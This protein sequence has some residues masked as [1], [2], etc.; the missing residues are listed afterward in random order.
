MYGDGDFAPKVS[1]GRCYR[2][3][4]LGCKCM[5]EKYFIE[6]RGVRSIISCIVMADR[7]DL[8]W[9]RWD[10]WMDV[11]KM[12]ESYTPLCVAYLL[13]GWSVDW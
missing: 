10:G 4:G 1:E 9:N 7:L 6:T 3:A 2:W 11:K 8:G 5:R 13:V 12:S